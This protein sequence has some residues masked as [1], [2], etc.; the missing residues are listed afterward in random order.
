MD[1][2]RYSFDG[3]E[4][5]DTCFQIM[6][7]VHRS[8]IQRVPDRHRGDMGI[9]AFS[10][11][12]SAI[13]YQ[14][15]APDYP[16]TVPDRA[17]KIVSK[18]QTDIPKL[19]ANKD[20]ILEHVGR[21]KFKQWVLLVPLFDS[22]EP[23][24]KCVREVERIKSASLPFIDNAEFD[25]NICDQSDFAS[26]IE[27][28]RRRAC[29]LHRVVAEEASAQDAKDWCDAN[30]S[31]VNKLSGKMERGFPEDS[32][33]DRND[34]MVEFVRWYIDRSNLSDVLRLEHP[35]MWEVIRRAI[36][37]VERR[38]RTFG[39]GHGTAHEIISRQLELLR[40]EIGTIMVGYEDADIFKIA[41]GCLADWLIEC[42]LDFP[43][44]QS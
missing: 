29:M 15:Y 35:E 5:Q 38:L 10:T 7:I 19:I 44:V 43:A 27:E 23:L 32:E 6:R 36:D 17:D 41:I 18:L 12:D 22:K 31:I 34:K 33:A 8:R 9:E 13:I 16:A 30:N 25:I 20:K 1:R 39:R 28:L 11:D 24:R 4:W 3:T 14:C 42:P 40:S 2:Y 26:E 37:S 21:R